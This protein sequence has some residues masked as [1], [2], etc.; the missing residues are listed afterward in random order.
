M[1]GDG[2][3][4][5]GAYM[6]RTNGVWMVKLLSKGVIHLEKPDTGEVERIDL[7]QWNVECSTGATRMVGAPDAELSESDKALRKVALSDLPGNV[8]I[9]SLQKEF[10]VSAFNDPG[11]FYRTH[12]P[13]L[14]REQRSYPNKSKVKLTPFSY[15][16]KNAFLREHSTRMTQVFERPG[17]TARPRTKR[18]RDLIPVP[19]HFLRTPAFSTYCKWIGEA[20]GVAL[21]NGMP[22]PKL[23]ASRYHD[24][25]PTARTM[26]PQIE[27]WLNEIIDTMWLT[28]AQN[29]KIAVFN[30]LK[31]R[32]FE[33]NRK[34][35]EKALVTP[36]DRHVRKY[37]TETVPHE[38]AVRRRKG[39]HA[40]D[41]QFKPVG[42]GP[43]ARW[44]L[45]VVEVDH[46][47][48]N[49]DVCDDDTGVKLG[50]PTITTALDRYSRAP[51]GLHVHFDGPSLG[52]VMTVLRNVMTMKDYLK[53][54]LP[55]VKA[56]YPC[57][58]RPQT[59]FF[60]RGTDF[61][62]DYVQEING[63]LDIVCEYEPVG[64]PNYKGKLERWHRTMAEQVA[65][66]LPGATP[67][68]DNDGEFRRDNEG[69]A[70]I[71]ISAFIR[72]LWRW[73][74][75]VYMHSPNRGIRTTPHLKWIEGTN[76][77]LPRP[78][79]S[80]D[81]LNIL[82]NR[83]EYLVPSNRG[84]Q[85]KHLRWN[86]PVLR[87]IHSHPSYKK[88]ERVKVRIDDSDVGNAWV[89]DPVS[90]ERVKLDP[91]M[92]AYM[93][94]RSLYQHRM[95]MLYCDEILDSARDEESLLSAIQV[96]DTE[97]DELLASNRTRK[98]NIKAMAR[99]RGPGGG[100]VTGEPSTPSAPPAAATPAAEI[101]P[102]VPID[103]SDTFESRTNRKNA[104][105]KQPS[106]ET[107]K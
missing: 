47:V 46:T 79:P 30:K 31:N 44:L 24:R 45:D 39:D 93:P 12:L 81:E 78:L 102:D 83:I 55:D 84:V 41:D 60:D 62:N 64:C 65:H 95:A 51:V 18:Q 75:T 97:A 91:V 100:L 80:A 7:K 50:R 107:K 9:S 99:Y 26:A 40:A 20:E 68:R 66:P 13:D 14:T 69:N 8:Q 101:V 57:Y 56:E 92:A 52:A 21:R 53:D 22:D 37:I 4:R 90:R 35:P 54:W 67:P 72:R 63:A 106:R 16:V 28:T 103:P 86:G 29:S 104:G 73:I 88:G 85:W 77:R 23:N 98:K 43:M 32:V 89:V 49:V 25:G 38:T 76:L 74:M 34:H 70:Y 82:L 5:R 96:L 11:K 94:G 6:R 87:A 59:F 61:D 10:F 71:T 15:L 105:K 2:E 58:G 48:A 33:H 36:S 27:E 42:E 1:A 19:A 17:A 3:L